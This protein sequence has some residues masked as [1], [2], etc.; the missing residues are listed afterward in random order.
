MTDVL[1]IKV[2]K[3]HHACLVHGWK[4]F[5]H[6]PRSN[7]KHHQQNREKFGGLYVVRGDKPHLLR[8]E[9]WDKIQYNTNWCG[10][11][12]GVMH[13]KVWRRLQYASLIPRKQKINWSEG[14]WRTTNWKQGRLIPLGSVKPIVNY[15][16]FLTVFG[17]RRDFIG[18]YSV[19]ER[20]WQLGEI[21]KDSKL[22]SLYTQRKFSF[23]TT[24][25]NKIFTWVDASYMI[26]S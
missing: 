11:T 22:C 13:V 18:N 15:E 7:I 14:G 25:L 4:K 1:Q 16:K 19:K 12:V 9:Y 8:Y 21:E 23:G 10:Q 17:Y 2:L 5:T 26:H 3:V 6:K 20:R 24:N